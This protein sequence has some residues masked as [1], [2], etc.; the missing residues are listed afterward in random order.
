[1]KREAAW[2]CMNATRTM[3]YF[4]GAAL[5][6]AGIVMLF[7]QTGL[8]AWVPTGI[9]VAGLIILVG[10]FVMGMSDRAKSDTHVE[11]VETAERE[12]RVIEHHHH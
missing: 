11:H 7:F 6:V 3:L 12:P 10:L 1:M 4:V 9:A 2:P 8:A 5:I